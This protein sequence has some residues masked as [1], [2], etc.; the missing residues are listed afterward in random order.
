MLQEGDRK[1]MQ[2]K[3]TFRKKEGNKG[4]VKEKIGSRH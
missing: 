3:E 1:I 4:G 2:R